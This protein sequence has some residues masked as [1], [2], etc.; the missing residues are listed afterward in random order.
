[1]H[2]MK[3]NVLY[4][5]E[6]N[7]EVIGMYMYSFSVCTFSVL[8]RRSWNVIRW[9]NHLSA[10]FADMLRHSLFLERTFP[11]LTSFSSCE[12][13]TAGMDRAAGKLVCVRLPNGMFHPGE[14]S[15]VLVLARPP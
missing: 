5:Y 11:S 2:L 8:G 13:V 3:K 6:Q 15:S 9:R 10:G 4:V 12:A 7:Y 14:R 1:M